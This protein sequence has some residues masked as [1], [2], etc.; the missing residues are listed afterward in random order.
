MPTSGSRRAA[1]RLCSCLR[2]TVSICRHDADER[3]FGRLVAV[4]RREDGRPLDVRIVVRAAASDVDRADAAGDEHAHQLDRLGEVD[5]E[6]IVGRDA[7][8]ELVRQKRVVLHRLADLAAGLIRHEVEHAQPH[9]DRQARDL[10]A[11]AVDDREQHAR[12]A[13]EVAAEAAG[14]RAGTQELV[15]QI[16]VAGFDVDE[17]KADFVRQPGGG[18]VVVDQLLQLVVGPHDRVVAGSMSNFASSS[19]W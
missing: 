5:R 4:A 7:E 3:I 1:G 6:R 13:G 2:R 19:G 10:L 11:D 14:A 15:Q 12:A 8:A 17:L 18:D 9:A 16:A